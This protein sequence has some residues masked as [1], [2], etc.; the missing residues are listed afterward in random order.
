ML[1]VP[2]LTPATTPLLEPTVATNLLSELHVTELLMSCEEES[3]NVPVA[4]KVWCQ[5]IGIVCLTGVTVMD[6]MV[7]LLTVNGKVPV[8]EPSCA[9]IVMLPAFTPDNTFTELKLATV[10]SEELQATSPLK[11]L[12]LPLLKWPVAII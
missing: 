9:V 11:L 4:V 6:L 10:G 7:A 12:V 1:A 2:C 8:I 3:V 5:P